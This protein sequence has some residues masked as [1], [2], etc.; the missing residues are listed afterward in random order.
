V[1]EGLNGDKG[2]QGVFK[3]IEQKNNISFNL[4]T[5]SQLEM[6]NFESTCCYLQTFSFVFLA[7]F[8]DKAL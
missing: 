4:P 5:L 8:H 1:L 7:Y 3:Q 6:Q 2:V